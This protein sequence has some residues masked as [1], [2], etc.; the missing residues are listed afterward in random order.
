MVDGSGYAASSQSLLERHYA[1]S[2]GLSCSERARPFANPKMPVCP[3]RRFETGD[4]HR[5]K[6]TMGIFSP[7]SRGPGRTGRV[8]AGRPAVATGLLVF[9]GVNSFARV[10]AR[11]RLASSLL[12]VRPLDGQ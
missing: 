7:G 3:P 8:A 10:A 11:H 2:L 5:M 6:I 12:D 9:T 1:Q 4:S